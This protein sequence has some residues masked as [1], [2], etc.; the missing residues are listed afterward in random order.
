MSF[1]QKL[2]VMEKKVADFENDKDFM[3]VNEAKQTNIIED[4]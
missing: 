3:I 1:K 4:Y 2:I